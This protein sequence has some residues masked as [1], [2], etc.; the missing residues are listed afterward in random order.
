MQET[1]KQIIDRIANNSKST[2]KIAILKKQ[3]DNTN[4]K[5]LLFYTYNSLYNYYI[6]QVPKS[7]TAGKETIDDKMDAVCY[8]LDRLRKRQVTGHAA[9]DLVE[10]FL[11]DF[12]R[13]SQKLI[14]KIIER[15]LKAGF[16]ESTVNK[17]F[18]KL[19]PVFDVVLADKY[20]PGMK[21]NREPVNIFDGTWYVNRKMDGCRCIAIKESGEIKFFSR[22]GKEFKTL[23]V[24]K[25]ELI[26]ILKNFDNV[27]LD[28]EICIYND[29]RE[30]FQAMMKEITRKDHTIEN[31]RYLVFD[32]LTTEEFYSGTSKRILAERFSRL[33]SLVPK[34]N[35]YIDFIKTVIC[36]EKNFAELS[37]TVAKD[38]WEGLMLRKNVVYENGRIKHLLKVK[39]FEDAEFTIEKVE[40]GMLT[41][42]EGG[43]Q[44]TEEMLSC[45]YIKFKGNYV[46][47]GSGLSREQRR[48]YY[49]HP[50]KILG[51]KTTIQYFAESADQDGNPSLRFPTVKFIYDKEGRKV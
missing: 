26:K 37:E 24:L 19:I 42:T 35:K 33:D 34:Q 28:G 15:D 1:L 50:E 48:E 11:S 49:K 25:N 23:D 51:H 47:V 31:P 5:R 7:M 8:L 2:E 4:L 12:D 20:K 41:F 40:N 30:E 39:K 6:K 14:T 10:N 36:T 44:K 22:N 46:G 38:G 16:S 43:K 32:C 29:G 18:S 27:V 21:I 13:D 3:I 45:F 17:V 9:L